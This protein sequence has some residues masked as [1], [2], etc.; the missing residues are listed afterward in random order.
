MAREIDDGDCVLLPIELPWL[1]LNYGFIS[2]R[3][4]TFKANRTEDR[5]HNAEA[6][7]RPSEGLEV[8]LG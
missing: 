4:R 6:Y 8:E 5:D 3:G 7:A 2:K 1:S